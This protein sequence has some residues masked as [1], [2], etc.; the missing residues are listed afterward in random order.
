MMVFVLVN[1]LD[2]SWG[3]GNFSNEDP[4][5][6]TLTPQI[7]TMQWCGPFDAKKNQSSLTTKII[8][9]GISEEKMNFSMNLTPGSVSCPAGVNTSLFTM[10]LERPFRN[11]R[12]FY[13]SE[14]SL[15]GYFRAGDYYYPPEDFCITK[16][17]DTIVT[18]RVC[19][20]FDNTREAGVAG[21]WSFPECGVKHPCLPKCC[22]INKLFTMTAGQLTVKCQEPFENSKPF[23]PILYNSPFEKTSIRKPIT[24]Y[25]NR[26][27]CN[28]VS[29]IH[30][31]NRIDYAYLNTTNPLCFRIRHDG[32]LTHRDENYNWIEIPATEYCSEGIQLDGSGANLPKERF[33]GEEKHYGVLVCV[34]PQDDDMD[35]NYWYAILYGSAILVGSVFLLLTFGVYVLLW[36]EHKIQGWITISHSATMFFMYC[37]LA[38]N[39]LLELKPRMGGHDEIPSLCVVSGVLTHFFFLSNFCW[40]TVICFNLFWSFR[41]I[42]STNHTSK[43]LVRFIVYAAF[44]WGVPL[45]FVGISIMLDHLYSH[46]PCNMVIVPEYGHSTC[47]VS[48]G[49]LG[50]YMYYPVAFLLTV[51][52]ILFCITSYKLCTYQKITTTME[53]NLNST[54]ELFQLITKL[55]FVMGFTWI[56]EFISWWHKASERTWYWA[57]VDMINILQ[58][59]AIFIIY[60]CN[61]NVAGSLRNEYPQLRPLFNVAHN[62][63]EAD[64][65]DAETSA[66]NFEST[67]EA[68]GRDSLEMKNLKSK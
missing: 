42:N 6:Q 64:G 17:N 67:V 9:A 61:S 38:S 32:K 54:E 39:H 18:V 40:L 26:L 30:E 46:E 24:Y 2:L 57:I 44:G 11:K 59:V 14:F 60:V 65:L 35:A 51:N 58:A 49:A 55:F 48:I 66:S 45:L 31:S 15:T 12:P 20:R 36:R 41:D 1:L 3:N 47:T 22:A 21:K 4:G 68:R 56:F 43:L 10:H 8:P 37:F 25:R 33:L 34:P 27:S 63:L 28:F 16:W 19:G 53:Q 13:E 50:P 5:N 23:E 7:V 62:S 52:A 29:F